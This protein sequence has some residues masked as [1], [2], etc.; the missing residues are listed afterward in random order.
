VSISATS[1]L[2]ELVFELVARLEH[3]D[4]AIVRIKVSYQ[5]LHIEI[6]D[7]ELTTDVRS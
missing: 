5:C 7:D 3:E 1:S 4:D 2:V 6:L